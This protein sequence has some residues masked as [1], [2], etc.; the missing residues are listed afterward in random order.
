VY[1]LTCP[2][3]KKKYT[4][5]TGRP[6]KVTFQ[7]QLRDFKCRKNRSKFNQHISENKHRIGP[8][9]NILHV[10]NVTN[11][12]KMM[13]MLEKFYI[14]RETEANNQINNKLTVQNNVIFN[15]V[16]Y[17]DPYRGLRSLINSQ[18]G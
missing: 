6:L 15:T 3:C 17:E 16:V 13:D 12:G 8:I 18:L 5:Q 4:G 7:E 2:N 9:E 10:I 1:Q 14:Y 11:K